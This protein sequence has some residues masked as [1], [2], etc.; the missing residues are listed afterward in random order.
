MTYIVL[1]MTLMSYLKA[2]ADL[3][4]ASP[5]NAK[6]LEDIESAM[7]LVC[8]DDHSPVTREQVSWACWVGDGKNRFYDKHQCKCFALC[9][10]GV[11]S[12]P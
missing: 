4:A 7:I 9:S 12:S 3:L 5:T 2:R 11:S 1:W 10:V 6:T 8:L